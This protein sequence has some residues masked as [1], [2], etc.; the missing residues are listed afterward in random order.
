MAT[1]ATISLRRSAAIAVAIAG[2][3]AVAAGGT[4]FVLWLAGVIHHL[5]PSARPKTNM[6]LGQ[7][8]S[9]VALLLLAFPGKRWRKWAGVSA[10]VA[11]PRRKCSAQ[12]S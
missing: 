2:L 5:P 12:A 9:G 3:L 4:M 8:L 10:A 1:D 6:A 7:F 11:T